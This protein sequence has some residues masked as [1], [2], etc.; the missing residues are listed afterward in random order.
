[1]RKASMIVSGLVLALLV[2]G[3]KAA[4]KPGV[5][6]TQSTG[7]VTDNNDKRVT[8]QGYPRISGLVMVSDDMGVDLFEQPGGQGQ[9]VTVYLTVGKSANQVE[10]IPDNFSD[11]DLKIHLNDNTVVGTDSPIKV[12]GSMLVSPDGSGKNTCLIT[13][14]DLIEAGS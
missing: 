13:E 5:A 10:D 12:T 2:T 7:C 11:A 14:I 8:L 4:P 1:M 6:I 9:S 3:C